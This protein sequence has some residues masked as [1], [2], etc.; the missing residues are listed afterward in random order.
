[1]A[2]KSGRSS[3]GSSSSSVNCVEYDDVVAE[4]EMQHSKAVEQKNIEM[5]SL[6]SQ[7]DQNERQHTAQLMR[8]QMEVSKPHLLSVAFAGGE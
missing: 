5:T 8:L 1:M 4:A 7:H 6:K 2:C 3:S